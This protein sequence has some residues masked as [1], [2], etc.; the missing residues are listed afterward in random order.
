MYIV[1]EYRTSYIP[2][3]LLLALDAFVWTTL[4]YWDYIIIIIYSI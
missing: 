1:M 4:D 2:K 3:A